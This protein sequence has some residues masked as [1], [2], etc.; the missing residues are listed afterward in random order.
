MP[1][2]AGGTLVGRDADV[3]ALAAAV[4]AAGAGE[5]AAVLVTG[6][7]GVGKTALVGALS[8]S[9]APTALRL[10]SQC[11]DLGDPGL[12]HLVLTDLLRGLRSLAA[13]DADVAAALARAP[14]LTDATDLRA[15]PEATRDPAFQLR[16]LDTAA[17]LLGDL[18]RTHG[19]LVVTVEDLQ[20]VD[21]S[22]ADL[23]TFLL[24]RMSTER[25]LVV[26]TVR[27]DGV[28]ARPRA[29]RL[30]A[31]LDRLPRVR[32]LDLE[33]FGA[34]EVAEYLA[35]S[36]VGE[37]PEVVAEVVRRTGGNPY[38]VAT[39]ASELARG[40]DV[41]DGV[42]RVLGQLLA[43]RVDGLPE[44]V[45]H[46]VRCAAIS[47]Q[48][49]S[50][51]V[52]RRVAGVPDA[53]LDAALLRAV[54]EGLLVPEGDGYTFPH[55]LLRAAVESDL[56]PGERARL[57]G[58]V[59]TA[60]ED[61]ADGPPVPAEVVHHAVEAGDANRVL[62]WSVR[63]ARA[64]MSVLAPTEALR[65]LERALAAWPTLGPA[66]R[67]D[68]SSWRLAV[69]AARAAGLAGEPGAAVTW[70]RRAVEQCDPEV[71]PEWAVLARAELGRRLV[72]ADAG[73]DA[74]APA[75]EAVRLGG[76]ATV[77]DV[78]RALAAVVLA[79]ALVVAHRPAEA[80]PAATAALDA[81]RT[82]GAA[83]LEVE[84]LSTAAFLDELDGDREAAAAR[85]GVALRLARSADE[86]AAEL[87]AHYA[88]ASMHY[89]SGDVA[90]ALPL[91][92]TAMDRVADSRLRWSEPG[93]ELRILDVVAR[94]VAGDLVGSL[95][96]TEAPGSPP[97][98]V[99][100]ARLAAVA[101]YAAVAAGS[102]DAASRVASLR[103]SWDTDP[104]VALVAGGCEVDLLTWRGE[105]GAA[106]EVAERA[107]A[108]LDRVVGDSAYGGLWLS[109]LALAALA[110][111]AEAGRARRE[112]HAVAGVE[113]RAETW[114][115][116]ADRLV[117]EGRGRPGEL[118]PEGRAWHARAVAE[119]ARLRGDPGVEEWERALAA[120]GYGHQPEQARCH[121]R[122]ATAL[123]A[124]GD[125][126]AARAHLQQAAAAAE[127]MGAAPLTA[128]VAATRTRERL[129][130]HQAG[131]D[132]V[133]T[134]REREVLGLVAEGLTNR[135]VGRR[136]HI[137]EKTA[138]V[139]LSNLMA[140]LSVSSRTEA[141]TVARRRGLLDVG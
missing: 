84:A 119:H 49:V 48:P 81:A 121:W 117:A 22:S 68:L 60:L 132:G 93:V 79:R 8:E 58:L 54:G 122:L 20:W 24:G 129:G 107:Q 59:A 89:Y 88:L 69:E 27:T 14:A 137:S 13:T 80:R 39:L 118:G 55:D 64:A 95:H 1:V 105:P 12:P 35:R 94:Y 9:L 77:G 113:R 86:P 136:L 61:G 126:D 131:V 102:T 78:P 123:V 130:S 74:V 138:S 53:E 111:A 44:P 29:R 90:G 125:R 97:P 83:G 115:A 4:A 133:L 19:P 11:V 116:R 41:R 127:W 6:E 87:R 16:L 17:T 103:G 18:G 110:D 5:A 85:L 112:A 106:V 91:L 62:H 92:R 71:D 31:D 128:A 28:A 42:P 37:D 34:V 135:E 82:A 73:E 32:R 52:L 45:R 100:A 3:A 46:V 75:R 98:D 7:A 38:F 72:E 101:C 25:L 40:G 96:A 120:F 139:H 109:A 50:D 43:S 30:L 2:P 104:Q 36:G 124:D 134:A 140:K 99:A 33:P 65:H 23:L 47:T 21:A 15:A 63:A 67:G 70:A 108:H 76:A 66:D 57:H 141:V 51:R 56:L 10:S 26:A 114:R